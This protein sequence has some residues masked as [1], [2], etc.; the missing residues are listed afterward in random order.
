MALGLL[1]GGFFSI[2]SYFYLFLYSGQ[3]N[4][5]EVSVTVS[6]LESRVHVSEETST[7]QPSRRRPCKPGSKKRH[8]Q[9]ENEKVPEEKDC[10]LGPKLIGKYKQTSH[11]NMEA[12][13][14]AEGGSWMFKRMALS[15][16]PNLEI[17][18][19]SDT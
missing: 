7:I 17:I 12:Y 9:K 1:I 8:C 18:Q 15:A 2:L 19:Y 14:D 5:P 4:Q 6:E 11:E 3:R 13:L 10:K 16:K